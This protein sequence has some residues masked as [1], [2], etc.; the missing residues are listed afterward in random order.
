MVINQPMSQI[1]LTN[2]SL[3]RLKKGKKRF[4]V[5]CYQN[6]VQDYRSGVEKDLDEVLQI[7]RVF[8]N[9]SKGLR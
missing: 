4:E 1:R 8:F 7:P 9:V 5:A 2:V 3:V 6:K